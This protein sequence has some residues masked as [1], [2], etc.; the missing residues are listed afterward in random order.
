ME[1]CNTDAEGETSCGGCGAPRVTIVEHE[2]VIWAV[3]PLAGMM[4]NV[5]INH[6]ESSTLQPSVIE[7]TNVIVCFSTPT[8]STFSPFGNCMVENLCSRRTTV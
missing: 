3:P 6:C 7:R 8:S 4:L 2:Y 1:Q 5:S